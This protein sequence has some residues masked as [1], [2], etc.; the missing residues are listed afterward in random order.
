MY[1]CILGLHN[2]KCPKQII[3]VSHL[4][5]STPAVKANAL[6]AVAFCIHAFLLRISNS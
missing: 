5:M 3:I 4:L 1:V 6:L 2:D